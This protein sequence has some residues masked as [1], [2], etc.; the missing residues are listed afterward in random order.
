MSGASP[1]APGT[2]D[3][4]PEVIR[5]DFFFRRLFHR[6]GIPAGGPAIGAILRLKF[7]DLP[8]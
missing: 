6:L 8:F 1:T 2:S 5:S 4:K 3:N 7:A